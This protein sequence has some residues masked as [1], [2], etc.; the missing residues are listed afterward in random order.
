M[1]GV[2]HSST[3]EETRGRRGGPCAAPRLVKRPAGSEGEGDSMRP[4]SNTP[5]GQA[6]ISNRNLTMDSGYAFKS[7]HLDDA[8]VYQHEYVVQA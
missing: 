6:L 8:S 3:S 2:S 1:T 5:L 4:L 7:W